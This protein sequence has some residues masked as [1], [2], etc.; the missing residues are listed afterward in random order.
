MRLG[1][2]L[3]GFL[4]TGQIFRKAPTE[5]QFQESVKLAAEWGV[6]A[7]CRELRKAYFG[8][9]VVPGEQHAAVVKLLSMFAQH[10]SMLSNQILIQRDTAESPTIAKAKAF[11]REHHTER[12]CLA[13]VAQFVNT[14]SCHFCKS[15]KKC[16]GLKF[17]DYVSL[18]RLEDSKKLLLNP[19]LRVS[20]IA[21]QV[22]FQSLTHFS[23]V[24][25]NKLG[26]SPTRY[27]SQ[28]PVGTDA[29]Q[30]TVKVRQ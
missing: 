20:E 3:I 17:T 2:R 21:Y 18:I 15:F 6:D 1:D 27:R 5:R 19:H 10:L 7:G 16:T 26:Q 14:S 11:I 13:Q 25:R 22:G 29:S 12:L 9:R 30:D 28:L 23:R 4:Q 24:F 8:T